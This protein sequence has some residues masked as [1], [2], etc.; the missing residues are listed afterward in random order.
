MTSVFT[1]AKECPTIGVTPDSV[2]SV[3]SML[4]GIDVSD[5]HVVCSQDTLR[6][7]ADSKRVWHGVR[8]HVDPSG[9][10]PDDQYFMGPEQI[11]RPLLELLD[12]AA[13]GDANARSSAVALLDSVS[14]KVHTQND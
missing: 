12:L 10:V 11:V 2:E 9:T 13:Q 8:V 4:M 5:K 6:R 1:T 3:A 7:L 14:V